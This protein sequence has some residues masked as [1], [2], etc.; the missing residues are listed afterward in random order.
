LTRCL[1]CRDQNAVAF[2]HPESTAQRCQNWITK[3]K[4]V[5]KKLV[6][7]RVGFFNQRVDPSF[8]TRCKRVRWFAYL[9]AALHLSKQGRRRALSVPFS[10]DRNQEFLGGIFW[11]CKTKA[12]YATSFWLNMCF[13][14]YNHTLRLS[15]SVDFLC[16]VFWKFTQKSSWG[17]TIL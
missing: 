7:K 3:A 5:R 4:R 9:W 1:L 14:C 13:S 10:G 12:W 17:N 6:W 8:T 16:K 15:Q 2:W 11:R